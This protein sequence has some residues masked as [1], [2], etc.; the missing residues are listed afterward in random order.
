MLRPA[1]IATTAVH[2]VATT[3][4]V[5]SSE[6]R[7]SST[8]FDPAGN[9]LTIGIAGDVCLAA[10]GLSVEQHAGRVL[11]HLRAEREVPA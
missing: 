2:R 9:A 10:R 4:P 7:T 8:W 11:S 3:L 6:T 5:W 1:D